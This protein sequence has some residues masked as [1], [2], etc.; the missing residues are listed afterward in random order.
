MAIH[1]DSIIGLSSKMVVYG[2]WM[3]MYRITM[4]NMIVVII[5]KWEQQKTTTIHAKKKVVT[6][7]TMAS[8][9]MEGHCV[10]ESYIRYED[11]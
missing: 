4:Y 1:G 9:A 2:V 7:A 5:L 10:L 6:M 3:F 8:M 11:I